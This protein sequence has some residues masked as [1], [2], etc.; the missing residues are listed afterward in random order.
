M[1]IRELRLFLTIAQESSLT[2]AAKLLYMTPQGLSKAVKNL[3][4]ELD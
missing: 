3:E 4:E 2:R 1:D